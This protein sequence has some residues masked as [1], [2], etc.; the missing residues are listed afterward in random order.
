MLVRDSITM[1][2]CGCAANESGPSFF[3]PA[4]KECNPVYTDSFLE[5][6]GA[7]KYSTVV[8]TPTGFLTAEAWREIVPRHI[9]GI[10]HVVVQACAK[11]GVDEQTARQ[12]H[13]AQ[14]FDGFKVHTEEFLQLITFAES[15][16]LCA[17]ENRDSSEMNQAFDKWVAKAGKKRAR[18]A[19]DLLRRSNIQPVIDQWTLVMVGLAMLRDCDASNVW[20]SSF[21]AVNMHPHHR[22][23]VE[24][25]LDKIRGF[26]TSGQKFDDEVIDLS[27]MLPKAWLET[28]LRQRQSWLKTIEDRNAEFD[29]ELLGS[30][31][32]QGMTLQIC[33][34]IFRIFH[35]EKE[36]AAGRG[37]TTFKSK[38]AT[39]T[40]APSRGNMIYHLHKLPKS[41]NA[42]P[43]ERFQHA[44][45]VRNRALGPDKAT[46]V[47]PHLD[48]EITPMNKKLLRLRPEDV[49]MYQVLQQST[50]KSSMRRKVAK[51][52]LAALGGASGMCGILN[53]PEQLIRLKANLQFA[54]SIEDVRSREK[55]MKQQAAAKKKQKKKDAE[56]KRKV[57]QAA[58]LQK[59][60]LTYE[61]ALDK[62]GLQSDGT[63]YRRHV[64]ELTG[65]QLKAVAF[66]QVGET[67]TGNVG[68]MRRAMQ[69][70]LPVDPHH[71]PYDDDGE[72]K[73]PTQDEL[74]DDEEESSSEE[75]TA[76]DIIEF[77][78]LFLGD[79]VE[80]YWEGEN[81]W[82]E[83]AITD[84]DAVER[85]FEVLYKS[86]SSKFW[87]NAKDYPVRAS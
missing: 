58:Q 46:T 65:P 21:I 20:E 75:T 22:I 35:A 73:Y 69:T 57:R 53:G 11:L 70:L 76:S 31:R 13:I 80:V 19:I 44:I 14:F 68:D 61:R 4:G 50:C 87:H 67:L 23:G 36:I 33:S 63:V 8:M 81:Q 29:V 66:F 56:E 15:N 7:K 43:L 10:W 41:Y 28:P 54:R 1:I 30:L 17:V 18:D 82:Y 26:I 47:S 62:L 84:V 55:K 42:T 74:F 60:K 72:P 78:H 3:S 32:K 12:L 25:W 71:E 39:N 49:N 27:A 2:R 16:F 24:D 64:K 79:I 5:Q 59:K 86:D 37:V 51:R 40:T 34:N 38:P 6:H 83:G 48:L 52:T 9:K 85:Q 45:T 77:E